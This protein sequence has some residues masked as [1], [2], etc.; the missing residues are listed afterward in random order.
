MKEEVMTPMSPWSCHSR[1]AFSVFL[2]TDPDDRL[3]QM[4]LGL[5]LEQRRGCHPIYSKGNEE[6]SKTETNSSSSDVI[7]LETCQSILATVHQS[8]EKGSNTNT[9]LLKRSTSA[10]S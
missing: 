10:L 3:D 2:G 5:Q 4:S 9:N 8:H 7:L 1:V 6:R